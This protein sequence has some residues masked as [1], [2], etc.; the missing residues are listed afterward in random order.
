[1]VRIEA[2]MSS[3]IEGED[4]QF[5]LTASLA[6]E[7]PLTVNLTVARSGDYIAGAPATTATIHTSG[8]VTYSVATE[9][10]QR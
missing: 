5:T 9:W 6:P 10:R 1:M 7:S 4:A 2:A 8:T 3:I